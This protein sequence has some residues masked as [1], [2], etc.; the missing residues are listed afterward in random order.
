MGFYCGQHHCIYK[1]VTGSKYQPGSCRTDLTIIHSPRERNIFPSA[2]KYPHC[3]TVP[4]SAAGLHKRYISLLQGGRNPSP[5]HADWQLGFPNGSKFPG[6]EYCGC[7]LAHSEGKRTSQMQTQCV[8][9]PSRQ[10]YKKRMRGEAFSC[11]RNSLGR[12]GGATTCLIRPDGPQGS[13]S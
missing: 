8:P 5:R 1:T 10:A 6:I 3:S 7:M 9:K 13:V 12:T 4:R 11:E 2:N